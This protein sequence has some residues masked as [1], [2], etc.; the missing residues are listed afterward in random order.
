M[1]RILCYG[2][3]N[4]WGYI[5]G[6]LGRYEEA[7]RWTGRLQQR[8]GADYRVIEAGLSGRTTSYDDPTS[9]YRNGRRGLG[10]AL[11]ESAPIDLL[12]VSLGTNDLK[13]TTAAGSARGLNA[14]L[15]SVRHLYSLAIGDVTGLSCPQILVIS[16]IAIGAEIDSKE[17][18]GSL[19]G[20]HKQSLEF[21]KHYRVVCEAVG[22]QFMDGGEYASPD[23]TDCVHMSEVSHEKLA[24]A[25]FEKVK[26]LLG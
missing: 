26:E 9:D 11:F 18:G 20:C 8:L 17:P 1:K 3:S 19:C 6:G 22:A 13:F 14:L 5:P 16:P 2:D 10:Y 7:V 23:P 12:I 15:R 4:T 21:A 24:E 25:V